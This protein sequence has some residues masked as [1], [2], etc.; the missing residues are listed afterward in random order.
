M[1]LRTFVF[2]AKRS[3]NAGKEPRTEVPFMRRPSASLRS[4]GVKEAMRLVRGIPAGDV[5]WERL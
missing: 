5:A 3:P 4:D 2:R 1:I